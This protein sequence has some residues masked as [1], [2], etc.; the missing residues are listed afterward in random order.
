MLGLAGA[1]QNHAG[2]CLLEGALSTGV[3]GGRLELLWNPR[4]QDRGFPGASLFQ[5]PRTELREGA[6]CV[7]SVP[8]STLGMQP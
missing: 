7:Q 3:G 8:R 4:A 1:Q 2:M 6:V 5:E